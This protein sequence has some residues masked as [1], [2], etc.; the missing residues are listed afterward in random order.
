M[1]NIFLLNSILNYS[2]KE[3]K[4]LTERLSCLCCPLLKINESEFPLAQVN[5]ALFRKTF[6]DRQGLRTFKQSSF[7]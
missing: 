5:F 6:K 7:K 2:E 1:V 3:K 4:N